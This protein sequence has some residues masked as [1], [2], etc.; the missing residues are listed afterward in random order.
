[1][2]TGDPADPTAKLTLTIIRDELARITAARAADD[3]HLHHLDGREL[4]GDADFAEL[5]LPDQ[6]HPDAATHRRI[7]ERFAE[8]VF[9]E[10]GPFSLT[11]TRVRLTT[12]LV[13]ALVSLDHTVGVVDQRERRGRSRVD[14][15]V[16]DGG[17]ETLVPV[18]L[19]G[20]EAGE[21]LPTLQVSRHRLTEA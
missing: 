16:L 21:A 1:M 5:P 20:D 17:V 14:V 3:P 2:A 19:P 13:S 11:A 9:G 7:G 6:L 18:V 4:Y 12:W 10:G 8:Q 15:T